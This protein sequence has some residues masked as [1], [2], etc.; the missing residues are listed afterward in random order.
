MFCLCLFFFSSF[1]KEQ[2]KLGLCTIIYKP[3]IYL[4]FKIVLVIC[5]FYNVK[6]AEKVKDTVHVCII[7]HS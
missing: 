1:W 6:H 7:K 2:I 5:Y 3:F 4:I